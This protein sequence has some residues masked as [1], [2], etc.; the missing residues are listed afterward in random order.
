MLLEKW[1]FNRLPIGARILKTGIAIV[2]SLYLAQMLGLTPI[3][4][5]ISATFAIQPTVYRSYLSLLEQFVASLVGATIAIVLV[6]LF[7]TS[8]IVVGIGAILMI[9]IMMKIKNES[10]MANALVT[11]IVIMEAQ[12]GNFIEFSLMRFSTIMLGVLAA[13]FVNVLLF[14]P[15]Y[16][17]RLLERII[18]YA[19]A[20]VEWLDRR[21]QYEEK[22]TL[23]KRD[24]DALRKKLVLAENTYLFFK[25]ERKFYKKRE[26]SKA[27]KLVIY[28]SMISTSKRAYEVLRKF[29]HLEDS[30]LQMPTNF[31]E[32]VISQIDILMAHHKQIYENFLKKPHEQ[33]VFDS[34]NIAGLIGLL[35]ELRN[36]K[37]VEES[38]ILRMTTLTA[39]MFEYGEHLQHLQVLL[40]SYQSFHNENAQAKAN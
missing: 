38:L 5:A 4:A 17:S 23:L 24:F 11:L 18:D 9:T 16:E 8:P 36:M 25:D 1:H 21:T 37:D 26:I 15:K 20:V 28:R 31:Q 34:T 19:T 27:R 3:L 39:S 13:F 30:F 32:R 35:G 12:S 40:H 7:G 6:L 22:P 33:K 14:P 2:V 29:H 10:Y